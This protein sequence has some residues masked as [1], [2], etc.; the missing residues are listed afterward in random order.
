MSINIQSTW[1]STSE[2]LSVNSFLTQ[3]LSP[4]WN[5]PV[6]SG[7]EGVRELDPSPEIRF[8]QN[9]SNI[10]SSRRN[11]RDYS[12]SPT[13][14]TPPLRRR[15]LLDRGILS[16]SPSRTA[17]PSP[18]NDSPSQLRAAAAPRV[19]P[20][21]LPKQPMNAFQVLMN[22]NKETTKAPI[23]RTVIDTFVEGEAEESD[24]ETPFGVGFG[25]T[26]GQDDGD[27]GEGDD[28]QE[29]HVKDLVD[30]QEMDEET[31]AKELVLEKAQSVS[32]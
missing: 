12:L 3:T 29:E 22:Q 23:D 28:G 25:I 10:G 31:Q 32:F 27:D 11:E 1:F 15:R 13:S 24:D 9:Q 7:R 21:P 8:S 20:R 19:S 18:A 17:S 16:A 5:Q 26:K 4:S 2:I 30:D 14:G 6:F